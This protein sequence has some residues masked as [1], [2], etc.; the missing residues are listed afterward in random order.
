M[1]RTQTDQVSFIRS[2]P[3]PNFNWSE[4]EPNPNLIHPKLI[5]TELNPNRNRIEIEYNQPEPEQN[6]SDPNSTQPEL[7]P[8]QTPTEWPGF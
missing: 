2:S 4:T 8:T 3:K 7:N 1:T 5:Q 6:L